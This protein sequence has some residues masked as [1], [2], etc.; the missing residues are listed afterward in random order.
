MKMEVDEWQ[1]F[2]RAI[3]HRMG[4]HEQ[5]LVDY[6]FMPSHLWCKIVAERVREY[7]PTIF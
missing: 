1:C 4:L 7:L 5:N 6:Q 3:G 2:T